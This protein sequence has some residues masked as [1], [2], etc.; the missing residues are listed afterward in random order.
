[1]ASATKTVSNVEIRNT[2]LQ[3]GTS[4]ASADPRFTVSARHD[5]D[6]VVDA[7]L[8]GS[9]DTDF[10]K[11]W[12]LD[13]FVLEDTTAGTD[14]QF[15]DSYEFPYAFLRVDV[16]ARTTPTAGDIDVWIQQA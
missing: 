15:R 7:T 2:V 12:T 3:S 14:K 5:E 10:S 11:K 6:A 1:M 16:Q 4:V 9:D 13:T 8:Y